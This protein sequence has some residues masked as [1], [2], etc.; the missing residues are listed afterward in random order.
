MRLVVG[1]GGEEQ[2]AGRPVV[3]SL[4]ELERP[5]PVDR[6]RLAAVVAQLA[7]VGEVPVVLG[8]GV[9]LA[10]A[11]VPNEQVAGEAP[12]GARRQRKAPRSVELAMLGD[13][14]KEIPGGVVDVDEALALAC[15]LVLGVSVL[16]AIRDEDAVA[17][18]LDAE[19]RIATR[20]RR[21]DEA[22]VQH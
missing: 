19:G 1:T 20:Q 8:V 6:E 13:A 21:I 16:L 17:D 11:E 15:D 2:R 18:R 14:A 22:A 12:E 10:V 4:A 9:D 5:K 3:P 7:S